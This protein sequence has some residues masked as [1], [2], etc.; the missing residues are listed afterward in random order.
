MNILLYLP[1]PGGLTGAP[2]RMLTLA[3]EL[4]RQGVSV[5]VASD[6]GTE[7]LAAAGRAGIDTVVVDPMGPLSA[8]GREGIGRGGAARLVNLF[9]VL[10]QNLRFWRVVRRER[11]DVIW[12]RGS[13]GILFAGLGAWLSGKPLVWDVD[14]ELPSVGWLRWLHRLGLWASQCVV[15]QYAQAPE[16][17]FGS[18]L[19]A[20]YRHKLHSIIPGIELERLDKGV[21]RAHPRSGTDEST[22]VILQV[23]TVCDRK[24]PRF[25][26]EV[27]A[28]LKECLPGRRIEWQLAGEVRDAGYARQLRDAALEWGVAS[29]LRFLGWR[30][31]IQ[32]LMA[33]AD[34]LVMPSLDE[35]VPNTVQEAMYMGLPVIASPVGGIPEIIRHGE[36]GWVL[37]LD[38]PQAWVEALAICA[39]EPATVE[40]VTG[41]AVADAECHFA[42]AHWGERYLALIRETLTR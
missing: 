4:R 20:R 39:R 12:I 23:G 9:L 28:R 15:C 36:T 34:V 30:E 3:L 7:L 1:T 26:V 29:E 22:Y 40:R 21:C 24:N 42:T 13:K 18:E 2:R 25:L 38:E 27:V 19:T 32:D 11:A 6:G 41:A 16:R 5:S 17:I 31:D 33:A 10:L 37:S 14:Y 35:G 8:R